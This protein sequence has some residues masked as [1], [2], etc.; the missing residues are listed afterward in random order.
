[1][2][3]RDWDI[4]ATIAEEKNISRAAE[5]LCI[6]QPALSYRLRAIEEEFET[7]AF[8]RT[9]K[10]VSLT[11]QGEQMVAYAREMIL[12]LQKA[13]ERL[14]GHGGKVAGPLR[15]GS[16]A[17]FANHELPRLLAGFLQRHPGVDV[18]LRTG[19]SRAVLEML[20]REACTVGIV[21]G[22]HPWTE[23]KHPLREEGICLLS[24][25]PLELEQLPDAPRITYGTDPSLQA[26]LDDWW[27]EH[28]SRPPKAPMVV[29][30][31][32]TCRRM[33]AH[34]LGYA[35]LPDI[36]LDEIEQLRP[37]YKRFLHWQ[38]GDPVLRRT[39]LFCK[40]SSLELPPVRAFVE[41]LL[42]ARPRRET[43]SAEAIGGRRGG[44][45]GAPRK[46]GPVRR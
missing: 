24:H 5:R 20:D 18:H 23:V 39:W 10:G 13:R 7:K 26:L 44:P 45:R 40:E 33:V 46:G 35:L 38:D 29:D 42:E 28:F 6:S 17:V 37:V 19:V 16:S 12:A 9:P 34:G 25:R 8:V 1:M 30:T 41:H 22:D 43:P 27:R 31:M 21:R 11:A 15:I 32:D 36:G 3:D 14:A 2:D 4:L